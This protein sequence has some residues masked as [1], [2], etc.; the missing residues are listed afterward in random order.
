MRDITSIGYH[1][2]IRSMECEI[3]ASECMGSYQGEYLYLLRNRETDQY[4]IVTLSYGSCSYCDYMEGLRGN[5]DFYCYS[6]SDIDSDEDREKWI[7]IKQ[8]LTE[9]RDI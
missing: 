2:V 8:D 3:V 4:G 7:K 5:Y 9:Y 6:E 1:E